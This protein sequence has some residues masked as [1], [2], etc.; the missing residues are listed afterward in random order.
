MRVITAL[1]LAASLTG[2]VAAR[3]HAHGHGHQAAHAAHAAQEKRDF[4]LDIVTE[5]AFVTVYP[6]GSPVAEPTTTSTPVAVET[7]P[8]PTPTSSTQAIAVDLAIEVPSSSSSSSSISSTVVPTTSSSIVEISTSTPEPTTTATPTWT[9]S[10]TNVASSTSDVV[11]S[12]TATS[13][14]GVKIYN[15]MNETVYLWT[16]SEVSEGMNTLIPKGGSYYENW[17]INSDGGG[18]SIK[19]GTDTE[20][21]S[22]LQFEYT[23]EDETLW[24][25]MS[26]INL[27]KDSAIVK[28]GFAVTSN[29][30]SCSTVTCD[31]GD[32]DCSES[33]QH[34]DDI[35]TLS[36][37]S[38]AAFVL[39]LGLD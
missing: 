32:S 7:T 39:T 23:K 34:P 3:P 2:M 26:S 29:D 19:M 38:S 31:A 10:T 33:Y 1:G 16:T 22:V 13:G 27:D 12:A 11:E 36:C 24:W 35:D 37:T 21:Q 20:E 17:Q 28:Y 8:T 5:Y 6:D 14:S 4:I 15:N 30:A 18:I 25:D 9:T